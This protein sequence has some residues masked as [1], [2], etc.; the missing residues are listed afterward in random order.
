[1]NFLVVFLNNSI[2]KLYQQFSMFSSVKMYVSQFFMVC[3]FSSFLTFLLY[4]KQCSNIA[5]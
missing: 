2:L 3:L 5:I 1:M 4:F